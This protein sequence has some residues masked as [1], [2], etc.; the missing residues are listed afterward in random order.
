[1]L[2]LKSEL[3]RSLI[4]YCLVL[5]LDLFRID[6]VSVRRKRSPNFF[7]NSWSYIGANIRKPYSYFSAVFAVTLFVLRSAVG[8]LYKIESNAYIFFALKLIYA[9]SCE[10]ITVL[11]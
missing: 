2:G 10:I 5:S 11:T 4:C 9:L 3:N 1:M 8:T 7:R 6:N